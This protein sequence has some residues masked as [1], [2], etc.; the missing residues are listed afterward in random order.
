MRRRDPTAT[1]T[2]ATGSPTAAAASTATATSFA[3]SASTAMQRPI[4]VSQ[5][6]SW[7]NLSMAK[8]RPVRRWWTGCR[9]L[10]LRF[11]YGLR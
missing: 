8:Q 5:Y 10:V 3:A 7:P 9:D 1:A 11:G 4:R 6:V 2:A